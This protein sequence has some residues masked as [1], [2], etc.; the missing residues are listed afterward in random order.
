MLERLSKAE[1]TG[2]IAVEGERVRFTHPLYA[3]AIYSMASA[4]ERSR[5]HRRL[6]SLAADAEQ[7][8]RHLALCTEEPD[9]EV[10]RTVAA[11]AREVRRRGA[12][13]DAAELAELA[14]QLTPPN[15]VD[16]RDRRRLEL[17]NCLV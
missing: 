10:A 14:I 5:A 13:G 1:A 11:A 12:P 16:E 15:E 9:S 6:A 8:A 17:G 3:S 4:E 2:V 7:R